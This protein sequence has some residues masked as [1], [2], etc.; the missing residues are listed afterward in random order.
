[1]NEIEVIFRSIRDF[2][3]AK[4]IKIALIP[5]FVTMLILYALFFMVADFS[6]SSLQEISVASQNGQ[7]IVIDENAPFYMVWFTYL[8]VFLFKY[9]ITSWLAGFLFY[10][11]G[12]VF[13]FQL[14][15]ILTIVVIGFLTPMILAILHK[16][17]YSHLELQGY[18]T[19]LGSVFVLLK[20][21]F[22]MMVLFVVLIPIYFIPILN[23]IALAFPIYYFFHKLLNFDVSSTILSKEEYQFIYKSESM[24]FRLRTL[25]LY[26][27]SM[28]PFIT[29]FT[30]VFYVIYLGHSYFIE[31]DKLKKGYSN[32]PIL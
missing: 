6:I 12:T 3:T 14:S 4:M 20:T 27:I 21:L 15:M 16:R 2:F 24:A 7:E 9:S 17:Y 25:F 26:F 11:V 13:V 28:I 32:A 19:I 30:A 18:G 8:I 31:L 23:M 22:I 1:M 29:L 10:S 5:L